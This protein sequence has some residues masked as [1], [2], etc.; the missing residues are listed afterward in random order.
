VREFLLAVDGGGSKTEFCL[1]DCA[2]G[3]A[4]HFFSGSTN[5]KI[6]QPNAD[7]EAFREGMARVF[8]GTGIGMA[9]IRGMVM[10]MAGVDAPEDHAHYL[11][12]GLSAGIPQEKIYVCNDSELAFY[13]KGTPP[14]LCIIAGTGSVSTGVAADRR[15]ARSG[16]WGSPI[17]DEG[18]GGWIGIQVLCGLLRYCDGYGEHRQ[19]FGD[20]R[21]HFGAPS[22]EELPGIL[23]RIGMQEIAAVARMVMDRADGGDPYCEELVHRAAHLTAEIACS[24]Y[25]KL[26]FDRESSV[27][28]VMAGSLFK[29]P[30]YRRKFL[31]SLKRIAPK[32]NLRFCQE[33]SSPVL[34]G[35]ALAKALFLK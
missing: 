16:G 35:I 18:S 5:Y 29:C 12:I 20:L 33:V 11:R 26:Q 6:S 19:V 21:D 31:E 13:A 24:V 4:R 15:T 14:G 25:A 17:S 3:D 32:E 22:F 7:Q 8:R 1:Y 10:G 23:S 27:D 2:T 34:G 30:A 9:Q 28:V